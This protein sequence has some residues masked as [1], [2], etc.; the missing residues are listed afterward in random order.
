MILLQINDSVNIGSTGRIAEGIAQVF[1]NAGHQSYIAFG[2]EQRVSKSVIIKISSKWSIYWHVIKTRLFDLHGFGSTI[3]TI[4]FIRKIKKIDPDIIHLHSIHG[5]YINVRVLFNYLRDSGKAVVWTLHDCWPFTGHCT[6]FDAVYCFKWEQG[7]YSCPNLR[8]Y[9]ASR[10]LDNSK[11][12]YKLKKVLFTGVENLTI[13]TP[14]N[15]LAGHVKKSFLKKYPVKTLPNGIDL[16]VFRAMSVESLINK[17]K[18][19]VIGFVL[20]VARIWDRRKGLADLVEL[21]KRLPASIHITIVGLT[22][23]QIAN[24]PEGVTGITRTE[25]LNDLAAL[26]S[27]AA[28]FVNPTYVDNFPTTNIE[29][30]SCGTPVIT[31]NTG[32]S[33]EAIDENTGFVVEKGDIKSMAEIILNIFSKGKDHYS[34]FCRQRAE[35]L[36]NNDER[37]LDYLKLYETLWK[38]II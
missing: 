27:A 19:P 5:Y 12:N 23:S 30:L 6:Y 24:M 3:A 16:S 2:R 25:N 31:Y 13:V 20:G 38:K 35:K 10:W 28:V 9:P 1:I 34:Y 22:Q 11:Q 37:Y 21:R 32:G 8:A 7:C 33:P 14:S 17:Y 36:Y 29:A 18:I 4:F 15:W 26:Y